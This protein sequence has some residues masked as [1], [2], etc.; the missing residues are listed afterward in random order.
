MSRIALLAILLS[1]AGVAQAKGVLVILER[2]IEAS[3]IQLMG[4][5]LVV[6]ACEDCPVQRFELEP[7]FRVLSDRIEQP[8]ESLHRPV[9]GTLLYDAKTLKA[10]LVHRY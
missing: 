9:P 4:K 7:G 2:A 3:S 10:R 5:T 6:R 1:L 8:I